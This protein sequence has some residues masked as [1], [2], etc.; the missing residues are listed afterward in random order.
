MNLIDISKEEYL[1]LNRYI[2]QG[3]PSAS[4]I[5]FGNEPGTSGLSIPETLIYLKDKEWGFDKNNYG[6]NSF[7]INESYSFPVGSEFARFSDRL[8]LAIE[9]P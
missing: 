5:I 6:H 7:T 2:G 4:L 1:L 3:S 9:N 8:A